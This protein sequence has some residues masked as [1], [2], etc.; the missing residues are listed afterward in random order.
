VALL[1]VEGEIARLQT[2]QAV[3]DDLL[4]APDP[5]VE[6]IETMMP[7]PAEVQDKVSTMAVGW[8]GRR[9]KAELVLQ[10]AQQGFG[11]ESICY[12]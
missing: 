10:C 11:R 8:F 6:Q 9:A 7:M 2:A 3:Q 4:G 12:R 5:Y 1:R